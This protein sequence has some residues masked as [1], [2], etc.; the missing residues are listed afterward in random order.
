MGGPAGLGALEPAAAPGAGRA[1]RRADRLPPRARDPRPRRRGDPA[2][3]GDPRA[4]R[5]HPRTAVT[6]SLATAL[7][8]GSGGSAGKEGPIAQ[9]GASVG[10]AVGQALR[11]SPDTVTLLL[12]AGAAAGV[13]ATFKRADRGRLLRARGDPAQLQHA[14]LLRGGAGRGDRHGDLRGAQ[15]RRPLRRRAGL[16]AGA[17]RGGA[18]LRR[19]RGNRRAGGRRLHA[20][21]LLYGG[22]VRAAAGAHAAAAGRRRAARRRAGAL[23]RRRAGAGRRGAGVGAAGRDGRG[24]RCCCWWC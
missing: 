19:A 18:A 24:G 13:A 12:A 16:P 5:I 3:R 14:Q 6:K 2:G 9:I 10:S 11:L 17:P 7:T 23:E 15:R 8:I 1:A 4:G 22:A 20:R 21:P